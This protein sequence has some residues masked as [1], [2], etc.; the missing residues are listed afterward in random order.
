MCMAR[1]PLLSAVVDEVDQA[2]AALQTARRF[3]REMEIEQSQ[4][5]RPAPRPIPRDETVPQ[6]SL[7]YSGITVT[8]AARILEMSED[9]VRR[10]LRAGELQGAP[11]SGRIGWRL[12]RAYVEAVAEQRRAAREGQALA[13]QQPPRT[14]SPAPRGR[15]PKRPRR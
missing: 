12:D 15:P 11:Y 3:L 8:Q 1:S 4:M 13:R 9:H 6:S 10:L 5:T 2:L 14:T 7:R